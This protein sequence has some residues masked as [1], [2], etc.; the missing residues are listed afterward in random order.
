MLVRGLAEV[1]LRSM[2]ETAS[3][4]EAARHRG[5]WLVRTRHAGKPWVVVV[6]PDEV[7]R[8]LMVVTAYPI[9]T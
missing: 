8:K 4:L 9:G 5:R 7:A 1:E 2:M 3:A 6:E